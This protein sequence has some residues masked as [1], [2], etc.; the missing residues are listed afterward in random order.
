MLYIFIIELYSRGC[1]ATPPCHLSCMLE[2]CG[3]PEYIGL[4]E[5]LSGP[6]GF[7]FIAGLRKNV[8]NVCIN[9]ALSTPPILKMQ[10]YAPVLSR[11][12]N[13]SRRRNFDIKYMEQMSK[14]SD[15]MCTWL[16]SLINISV[17]RCSLDLLSLVSLI[18]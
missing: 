8:S 2:M 6:M 4:S 5:F 12:H 3:K 18:K 11:V 13:T 14:L 16:A 1:N 9:L 15:S 7:N 10:D 17:G